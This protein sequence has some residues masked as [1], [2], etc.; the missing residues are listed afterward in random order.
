MGRSERKIIVLGGGVVERGSRMELKASL[1]TT[2][3]TTKNPH[4]NRRRR[5]LA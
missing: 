5:H 1:R 2:T 4:K 3:T